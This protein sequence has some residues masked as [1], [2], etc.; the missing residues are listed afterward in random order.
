MGSHANRRKAEKRQSTKRAVRKEQIEKERAAMAPKKGSG[1]GSACSSR[2][3]LIGAA[4]VGTVA[5][6]Y[7]ALV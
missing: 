7:L 6:V 2:Q 1:S 3:V 4:I 5:A